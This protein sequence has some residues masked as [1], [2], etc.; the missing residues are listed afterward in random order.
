MD[1]AD[2]EP[3]QIVLPS[4]LPSSSPEHSASLNTTRRIWCDKTWCTLDERVA[5]LLQE[6]TAL[7]EAYETRIDYIDRELS[8]LRL[9][10]NEL[11]PVARL[12]PE[13]L[14]IIFYE[15]IA[16]MWKHVSEHYPWMCLLHVC[17]TWRE[18]ALATPRLWTRIRPRR[19]GRSTLRR[20]KVPEE[21]VL[22]YNRPNSRTGGSV[23]K[24]TPRWRNDGVNEQGQ[25]E[26]GSSR[27]ASDVARAF[28]DAL[29]DAA[30]ATFKTY[31]HRF[32]AQAI[33][34]DGPYGLISHA[35]RLLD[36]AATL[37]ERRKQD[38]L[39]R[40]IRLVRENQ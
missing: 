9:H 17:H 14:G 35:E 27:A 5:G 40:F 1:A 28:K 39:D 11:L 7:Q 29:G 24:A 26:P 10:Q 32:D 21:A 13:L 19:R 16:D 37:D 34:L 12:P 3:S 8:G 22:T 25:L 20:R 38:L 18:A 31:V 4:G 36:N 15:Y 30:Y 6:K 33:P 2:P 23:V